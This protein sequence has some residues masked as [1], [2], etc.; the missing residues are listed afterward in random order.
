M[1]LNC[2]R[3]P[4]RPTRGIALALF[5]TTAL[6]M[7]GLCAIPAYAQGAA[8]YDIPAGPL[9]RVLNQ[10]ARQ[11]HVELIYDAPLTQNASSPGLKGSFGAAEGLSRILAGT[12]LTYRQTGPNMFTL[13]RAPTADAGTVE[14]GPLR[15][16][17]DEGSPFAPTTVIPTPKTDRAATDRSHSYAARAATVAGKT[18]QD[19]R[20]IPQSVSVVTRQ[21]MDDQ[22]MVSVEDALRQATGVTAITYGDGTAY[23]QIRGYPAEVQFDGLPA[24]SG[25]QYLGQYDLAVY[26]RVEVLRGPSGL[27][28]GSG[29]PAGTVNLV[30][31]RP[32]DEFGWAG[33]VMSGRWN[34]FHG[35]LDVTGPLDAAG[36]IR[37]RLVASGQDRDFF[38]DETHERHGLVYGIVD[39]DLDPS[40]VWTVSGTLQDQKLAPFD[41]G[42]GARA[43]G[44]ALNPPRSSFFGVNWAHSYTRS[45]EAYS[46]LEHQFGNG[47]SA[48]ASAN[49]RWQHGTGAYGYINGLVNLNDSAAYALQSQDITDEWFGADVN[50]SGPVHL[51]GRTHQLLIGA[52]YAWRSDLS[53]SGFVGTSV[54]DVFAIDIPEQPIPDTYASATRTTQYGFYAQGRFSLA[55]PVT[56][57]L[58]G[59]LTSYHSK[60]WA[61]LAQTGNFTDAPGVNAKFTPSAGLV[62]NVTSQVTFYGSYAS[63][64]VPQS[65]LVYG[66]GTLKPRTGEQFEIGAK[67]ALLD[68]ALNLSGALFT[69]TDRNRAY[70]DPDHP[71]TPAYYIA[72]GKVRSRGVELEASGEVLPGWSLFAGYTY[73]DT[74]TLKA[75]SGQGSIFDTEEPKH[76]F[77]FWSTY[78]FGAPDRPG[79]QL[80]GGLRA[81]SKTSRGGPVQDAYA[82]VDAQ[83]GYRLNRQW[84]LTASVTNLFDKTY[85]ARL[86]SR[87][88][89]VYGEP[90]GFT[91]TLRKGF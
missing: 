5:A 68:G 8:S 6:S 73:L 48:K 74:K 91:V 58:G 88:Y 78:R 67:A 19:L 84:S 13:E 35:D 56:L 15:V 14:L 36:T 4:V 86:P 82:V 75:D 41:Y 55:D 42:P 65:N 69:M 12:G 50:V 57:V 3:Q 43:D 22:N 59:R 46:S 2:L 27:L 39:V 66:G 24:N 23:F 28:Q 76:S 64:F 52:N 30:R 77:K 89:S 18:A 25:L 54:S 29:E 60:A 16:N 34:T 72:A 83:I 37:G 63:I 87:F 71:G 7:T 1:K 80:G 90:R 21:R 81:Q 53:R 10:F 51:L 40:T 62:W 31:K 47:W 11:A 85:Y 45:R 44:T 61:G 9:T 20:E 38:T 33:S 70:L 79:F 32:H 49:Y 17:G 26:D